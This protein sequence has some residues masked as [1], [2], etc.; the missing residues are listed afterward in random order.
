MDVEIGH[1]VRQATGHRAGDDRHR[2]SGQFRVAGRHSG[3]QLDDLDDAGTPHRTSLHAHQQVSVEQFSAL[4]SHGAIC[5][6]RPVINSAADG[7]QDRQRSLI[8]HQ[9]W[10]PTRST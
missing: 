5:G 8:R 3:R 6:R 7:K 9:L 4:S 10:V 2:Q 1:L